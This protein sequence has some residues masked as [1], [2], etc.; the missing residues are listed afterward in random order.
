MS[1]KPESLGN[2]LKDIFDNY[3][4][5]IEEDVVEETNSTIK[6][7]KAE[8]KSISPRSKGKR[9]TPY[10]RGWAT[11]QA[12]KGQH[13]YSKAIWNKTNYQ[14]THLLEFGHAKKD[15]TGWVKA[16]PHIRPTEEKYKVK[17]TENLAEKIRRTK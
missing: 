15:G 17:F 16:Q 9:E 13:K 7:A 6:E 5:D 3:L 12:K 1:I 14:L 11:K 8:L 10:Y 2:E 4:K